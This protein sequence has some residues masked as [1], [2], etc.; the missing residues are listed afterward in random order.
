MSAG[1]F[2]NVNNGGAVLDNADYV[3]KWDGANWS[4][5][6]D[7]GFGG[8]SI[9]SSVYALATRGSEVYAGGYFYDVNNGG[10]VDTA[11][12]AVAMWDGSEWHALGSDGA[13]G[14]SLSYVVPYPNVGTLGATPTQLYVAG[15]FYNVN[16]SGFPVPYAD[17]IAAYGIGAK[18]SGTTDFDADLMADP[19]KFVPATG[20]AWWKRS[21]DGVWQGVHLGADVATYYSRSD[22][23][24]DGMTDPAK[25]VSGP[26]SLWYFGSSSS[27]GKASTWARGYTLLPGSDFD[28]DGRPTRRGS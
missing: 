24:G 22:F 27:P 21:T 15:Y 5:L 23:D 4:G 16:D 8:G 13:G 19:A 25:Y 12:D 3:A 14:G 11:A 20:Y 26:Q 18:A 6:G 2:W 1:D 28:G 10:V 7:D 17:L 9:N